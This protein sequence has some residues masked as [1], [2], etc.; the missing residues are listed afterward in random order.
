MKLLIEVP[1]NVDP[2]FCHPYCP[3]LDTT[4]GGGCS[5]F[6]ASLSVDWGESS[7]RFIRCTSCIYAELVAAGVGHK[8]EVPA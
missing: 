4:P 1:E 6:G 2:Q 3:G 5:I 7:A 8:T